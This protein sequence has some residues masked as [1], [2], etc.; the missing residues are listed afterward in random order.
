MQCWFHLSLTCVTL[1]NSV[2]NKYI[3]QAEQRK[4]VLVARNKGQQNELRG[5]KDLSRRAK[6]Q[7]P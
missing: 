3:V 1:I 4:Q 2:K 6:K 5:P 7:M